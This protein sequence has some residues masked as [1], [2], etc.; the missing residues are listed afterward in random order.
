M[1][2]IRVQ[3]GRRKAAM[4]CTQQHRQKQGGEERFKELLQGGKGLLKSTRGCLSISV[5]FRDPSAGMLSPE[6]A[7]SLRLGTGQPFQ[8][9]LGDGMFPLCEMM[10]NIVYISVLFRQ[11]Y[12]LLRSSPGQRNCPIVLNYD[13]KIGDEE[14]ELCRVVLCW[15]GG[16][17]GALLGR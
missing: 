7:S 9:P 4:G 15:Q 11:R 2:V 16:G 13:P 8:K 17:E 1:W 6:L 12:L 3:Q 5:L 14:P 10:L